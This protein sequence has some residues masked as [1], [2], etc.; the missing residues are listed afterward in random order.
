MDFKEREASDK[1][2]NV[3]F[4]GS[5]RNSMSYLNLVKSI[6]AKQVHETLELIA[7]NAAGNMKVATVAS[8]LVKWGYVTISHLGTKHG[9]GHGLK[10]IVA[11]TAD[12]QKL[13][14]E[15]EVLRA[16]RRD[17]R[18]AE[19]E[20]MP[21]LEEVEAAPSKAAEAEEEPTLEEVEVAPS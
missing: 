14:D 3:L 6:F 21:A 9:M 5:K 4:F 19:A 10:V 11:K 13:Y 18:A 15:F 16:E 12:F 1:D 7:V 20:A 2:S 17:K 8:T